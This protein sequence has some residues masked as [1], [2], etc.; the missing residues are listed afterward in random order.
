MQG[1]GGGAGARLDSDVANDVIADDGLPAPA[2]HEGSEAVEVCG[3][4]GNVVVGLM[5]VGPLGPPA[6]T[7]GAGKPLG[8]RGVTSTRPWGFMDFGTRDAG[9]F[10]SDVAREAKQKAVGLS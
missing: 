4:L 10:A 6:K 3:Q 9:Q 8:A 2:V 7:K 5:E 1:R